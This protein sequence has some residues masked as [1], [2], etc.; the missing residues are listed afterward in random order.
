MIITYPTYSSVYKEKLPEVK[1]LIKQFASPNLFLRLAL[2]INAQL[3]NVGSKDVETYLTE[4]LIKRI[5]QKDKVR[6]FNFIQKAKN[7]GDEVRFLNSFCIIELI[8]Q[9]LIHYEYKELDKND[10]TPEEELA[11]FK[12]ILLCNEL[13]TLEED[14]NIKK[15]F[16]LS[17]LNSNLFFQEHNWG[18]ILNQ[19]DN[20]RSLNFFYDAFRILSVQRYFEKQPETFLYIKKFYKKMNVKNAF[21][22][23]FFFRFP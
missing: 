11:F 15:N 14:E 4:V 8:N 2:H 18:I 10:S 17:D 3:N 7:A 23:T 12:L 6:F 13:R 19:I 1:N 9:L 22:Y 5:P 21:E 20:N 16:L